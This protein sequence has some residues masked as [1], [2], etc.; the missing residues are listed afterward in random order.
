MFVKV[1]SVGYMQDF[2]LLL[3]FNDGTARLFDFAPLIEKYPCFAPLHDVSVFRDYSLADG[4]LQWM[5]GEIDIAPEFLWDHG[6]IYSPSAVSVAEPNGEY[7]NPP[8]IYN[9]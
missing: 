4:I 2:R 1:I 6:E 9:V 7:G 5:N 3:M 8:R